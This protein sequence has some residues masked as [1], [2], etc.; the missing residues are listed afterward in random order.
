[1]W[2]VICCLGDVIWKRKFGMWGGDCF[3]LSF[4]I[5]VFFKSLLSEV[6]GRFKDKNC[7]FR[8]DK[9]IY[10]VCGVWF[11]RSQCWVS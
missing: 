11:N 10:F 1:M 6:Q 2:G 5:L 4:L 7:K 3:V 9:F 8:C